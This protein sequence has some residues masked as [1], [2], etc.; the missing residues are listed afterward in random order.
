MSRAE[1]DS[2]DEAETAALI[3]AVREVRAAERGSGD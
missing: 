3:A 1:Y 2:Y